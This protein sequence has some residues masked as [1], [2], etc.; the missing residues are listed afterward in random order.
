MHHGDFE[1]VVWSK[2]L[3]SIVMDEFGHYL[4]DAL[5]KRVRRQVSIR[6]AAK[7]I[8]SLANILSEG[9][10]HDDAENNDQILWLVS[11][12]MDSGMTLAESTVLALMR[13]TIIFSLHEVILSSMRYNSREF[14]RTFHFICDVFSDS[15]VRN[16]QLKRARDKGISTIRKA[17]KAIRDSE[18]GTALLFLHEYE[19][20]NPLR[21]IAR[22]LK[23][24]AHELEM[25]YSKFA[26]GSI[27][28]DIVVEKKHHPR[29]TKSKRRDSFVPTAFSDAERN[30]ADSD[31]LNGGE[32]GEPSAEPAYPDVVLP[33]EEEPGIHHESSDDH[34]GQAMEAVEEPSVE[35]ERKTKKAMYTERGSR[36][37]LDEE[38]VGR[39][40]HERRREKR[41]GAE[42][43]LNSK[44]YESMDS[45]DFPA[46]VADS[47]SDDEHVLPQS[48]KK[49]VRG[50]ARHGTTEESVTLS[51]QLDHANLEE[52]EHCIQELHEASASLKRTGPADPLQSSLKDAKK[53]KRRRSAPTRGPAPPPREASPIPESDGTQMKYK[54]PHSKSL[55]TTPTKRRREEVKNE[56]G[57]VI[58]RGRFQQHEDQWLVEGIKKYGWGAWTNIVNEY[59]AECD[60]TRMP[61]SLKDRARTLNLDPE[62]Y[63]MKRGGSGRRRAIRE[64]KDNDEHESIQ[65]S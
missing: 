46:E 45:L 9:K 41:A 21:E 58:K 19:K 3:R 43:D 2:S 34:D 48:K 22:L 10:L 53:A 27:P 28:S 29:S 16:V 33:E 63:P 7:N 60:Y 11:F 17:A 39:V 59:Y 31:G 40:R 32:D 25:E 38:S 62:K 15:K 36:A 24:K 18:K 30:G 6:T 4:N 1:R 42:D 57:Q 14:N 23:R 55:N 51:D 54:T 13:V 50:Q 47:E 5:L 49:R 65:D 12:I 20:K 52:N 35:K 44:E 61:M 26:A 56:F 8:I 64:D 37:H